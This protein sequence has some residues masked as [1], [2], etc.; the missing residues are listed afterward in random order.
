MKISFL[1]LATCSLAATL[2]VAAQDTALQIACAAADS[3]IGPVTRAQ[4]RAQ[5]L[6]WTAPRGERI[7]RTGTRNASRSGLAISAWWD[8]L[9]APGTVQLEMLLPTAEV[10]RHQS[11]GD[12]IFIRWDEAPEV[13]LG[14]P[15]VARVEG[16]YTPPRLPVSVPLAVEDVGAVGQATSA[17]VRYGSLE[18]TFDAADRNAATRL[19]RALLC[20]RGAA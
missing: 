11:L 13:A 18:L 14:P 4:A 16:A 17:R 12:S 8:T 20:S 1:A 10:V 7:A 2:A 9:G 6:S 15:T 5:V 3:A 19:F